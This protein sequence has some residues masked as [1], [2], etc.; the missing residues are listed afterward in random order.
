MLYSPSSLVESE[1]LFSVGGNI[2]TPQPNNAGDWGGIDAA[3]ELQ[4]TD[5]QFQ[6]QETK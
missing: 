1:R 3:S 6:L 4:S 2:L 5:L